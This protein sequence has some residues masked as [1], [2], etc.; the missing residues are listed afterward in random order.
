LV[1]STGR[2]G[3]PAPSLQESPQGRVLSIEE[4]AAKSAVAGL[5]VV[6]S[7]SARRDDRNGMIYTDYRLRFSEVWK[8]TP[9]DDFI[10]MKAGGQIGDRATAIGGQD[11]TLQAGEHIVVFAS[12]SSL[13]NHTVMGLRQGLY[14]VG[15]GSD[16]P[17]L[18]ESERGASSAAPIP[19]QRFKEHVFKALGKTMPEAPGRGTQARPETVDP[20]ALA[21][22]PTKTGSE[23]PP[24]SRSRDALNAAEGRGSLG[25]LVGA[26]L[27]VAMMWAFLRRKHVR[28]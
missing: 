18:R 11:Y 26:L 23:V 6:Q 16:R 2:G 27:I 14:R 22:E 1:L 20:V 25:A 28:A 21:T 24:S 7:A 15:E 4:M 8:G 17:L 3:A 13:G 9:G 5:A 10:L 12:P 19:L